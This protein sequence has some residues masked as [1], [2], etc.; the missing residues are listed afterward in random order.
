MQPLSHLIHGLV[1][2]L[3]RE[4]LRDLRRGSG[5]RDSR[6][7]IDRVDGLHPD[8]EAAIQP[9]DPSEFRRIIRYAHAITIARETNFV[10]APERGSARET[11]LS[12]A[13]CEQALKAHIPGA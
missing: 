12:V 8:A 3:L 1:W 13:S 9:K 5:E 7:L 2:P 6:N 4:D 11:D 10:E